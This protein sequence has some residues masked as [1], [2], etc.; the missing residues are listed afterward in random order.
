MPLKP[1]PLKYR[2]LLARLKK[3]GVIELPH[4]GK[5][6]ER[7]LLKPTEPG[8]LKGPQFPVKC[9]G[10]STEI[11]KPVI[12]AILNRFDILKDDFWAD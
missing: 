2:E 4:R 3:Y 8:S 12:T 9:H 7:V 10:E 5:G 1:R 11:K 6:S